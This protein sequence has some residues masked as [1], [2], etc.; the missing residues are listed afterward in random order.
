MFLEKL[1]S[2][3]NAPHLDFGGLA[4]IAGFA[5]SIIYLLTIMTI[6]QGFT[7][8]DA[9]NHH[10]KLIGF[11]GGVIVLGAFCFVDDI[12]GISPFTKLFGQ[13]LAAVC[14]VSAGIR[15]D[16][17]ILGDL[18]NF[19]TNDTISIAITIIWIVGIANAIN[20]IDGLDGLSAG[21]GVIS[22][23]SLLVIFALNYS[24]FIAIILITALAGALLG[25]IPFNFTPAKTFLGDTGSNFL[26]YCL[27]VISILRYSK[28]IYCRYSNCTFNSFCSS[29]F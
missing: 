2:F 9:D 16:Q 22:C 27:A 11:F 3:T 6:E 28:N 12:K 5:V 4:V 26:G 17:I 8:V 14:A 18:G 10:I 19:I 1:E 23:L 7:L 21:I 29:T 24:P 25:F 20:L 13:I 15:I